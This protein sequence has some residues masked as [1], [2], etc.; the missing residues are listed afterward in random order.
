MDLN[1]GCPQRWAI[2]DGYGVDLL[3]KPQLIKELVQAVRNRIPTPF[4]VSVKIR[5]LKDLNKT[6]DLC[7]TLEKCGMSFLT[8]HARTAQMRNQ[9]IDLCSLKSVRES[10]QIPMIANGGVNTL[11]E[12]EDLYESSKCE[13]I[14]VANGLLT[15]PALFSGAPVTPLSCLQ[16]WLNIASTIP[17]SFFT[18]H[19]HLVFMLEKILPKTKRLIF[20]NLQTQESSLKF[21]QSYYGITP[22]DTRESLKSIV[23][24][25]QPPLRTHSNVHDELDNDDNWALFPRLFDEENPSFISDVS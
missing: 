19:H 11:R 7:R 22:Q 5:L 17:T 25:Y 14:M 10:V 4:S 1:C 23:C 12:A 2:K 18:M 13:G 6:I 15:N 20:N 9:P 8:V 16:D 24:S 21:L 3:S